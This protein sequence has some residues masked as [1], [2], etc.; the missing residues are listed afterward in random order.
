MKKT[1]SAFFIGGL[2]TLASILGF[3][4]GAS[5]WANKPRGIRIPLDGQEHHR[6]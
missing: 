3:V 2:I 5:I 4:I 1:L 6:L